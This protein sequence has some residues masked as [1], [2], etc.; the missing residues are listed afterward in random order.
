MARP[1][2]A[3]RIRGEEYRIRSDE[4]EAS[5]QRVAALLDDFAVGKNN[6][7]VGMVDCG[8]SVSDNKGCPPFHEIGQSF[9]DD[10]LGFTV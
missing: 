4:D 7:P 3:V 6:N 8:Q 2:V 1:S 5:L 10:S 9:L